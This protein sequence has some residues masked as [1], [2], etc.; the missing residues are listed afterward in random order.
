MHIKETSP[1]A[2]DVSALIQELDDYHNSIYPEGS[3]ALDSA[4]E[5]SKESVTFLAAYTSNKAIGCGAI[6]FLPEGYAELKRMYTSPEGRG[7]GVAKKII[8]QLES[9]ALSKGYNTI[10]LET[11]VHQEAAKTLYSAF[12][13][14]ECEAFGNY[15]KNSLSVF[16]VKN[17]NV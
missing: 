8:S 15:K 5:L 10:K 17:L 7:L 11:G 9:T 3:H 14:K 1:T 16:M 6:K 13:Y 12:G 4:E 2:A